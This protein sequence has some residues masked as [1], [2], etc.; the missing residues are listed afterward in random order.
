MVRTAFHAV[1][2][3]L[4]LLCSSLLCAQSAPQRHSEMSAYEQY[5][6]YWT[7]EP[8]WR[9]ELQLRNNLDPGELTVTP[10]LRTADGTETALPPVTIKSGD[11]ASL[12][13]A[14]ALL[15]AAPQLV[16]SYGS[17]VLGYR[18]SVS[19]ALYAAVMVG[20][21]GHPIAFH[22]DARFHSAVPT[23]LSREG[24]WWL[25]RD[26]VSDYLIL[27]NAGE[28]K[29]D[30][31]LALYDSNGRAWRHSL[32]VGARQT[33]RLSVRSL[34][35]RAG[36]S[37]LY[38]GIQVEAE[39]GA[40]PL[41][42]THLIFD[43]LGGFG[44]MMKMFGHDPATTLA[45]RSF[46]GAKEWTTRAPM[47]ALSSPDPALGL[48]AG[49][50][51]QPKVFVR[52]TSTKTYTAHIRFNWRSATA[53]GKTAPID[54][55]LKPN[56]AQAVDVAALQAQKLIPADAHWAAVV[57]SAPIQPDELLAVAASYDQSGRYGAQT[58]FS[59][60]L[61]FHWEGGMWQVDSTHNSLITATN[62]GSQAVQAELTILYNHGSSQY[63][64]EQTLAPDEQMLVDLGKLIRNQVPDK[65]GHTLPPD[66][67][68][69]AY[70]LR[71]LTDT[72][73]GNLYEGKVI[74]DKTY[75]H[76]AYGCGIC[77]G[78][79]D[80][81]MGYDPL[82]VAV[83]SSSAQ[84]VYVEESCGGGTVL[85]TEDF[86]TWSTGNTAI[87][88][89]NKNTISGVA[90]GT[91]TDTAKSISLALGSKGVI[92]GNPCPTAFFQASGTTNVGPYQV[93][94]IDTASQ[95]PAQCK[96]QGQAGWVRNVTNQVQ[97]VNGAA[98][99]VSGLSVSDNIAVG[100][101]NT[102]GVSSKQEGQTPTTG[103]GSFPDTYFVCST[104]CPGSGKTGAT[105]N[106]IV[107]GIP[108]LHVDGLVY[109]CG[110][111]SI[112]GH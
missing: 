52:N 42:T 69:G 70:R 28:Q 73:V 18:A 44:A 76:A 83:A 66:L 92:D 106:W 103:D 10:A 34:L 82:G 108:L 98:Y 110:S 25:P 29:V 51:L 50:I 43:E 16:G 14:D 67:T 3:S 62:G 30:A 109:E 24:I 63:K 35:Q 8:G 32:S 75:G 21:D 27:S 22:V 105:Q 101:P 47:L 36:L 81:L 57:L 54:L 86:P 56:A 39:G 38:G 4:L 107:A 37:G 71:D 15:K 102:L 94:P 78:Y 74:V 9:T 64:V 31:S 26:S 91:T 20:M 68:S 46:G 80:A 11:V 85:L 97:Y 95:G 60:Q 93:E 1:A 7:T 33:Q 12:D 13:L 87:A 111:I 100:A 49:T 40:G 2:A 5:V 17:L 61:A 72:A 96:V 41:D 59:D 77:C 89:A 99:A 104:A 48:P 65:D 23:K 79:V 6:A 84:Q 45:S 112:D 58:P 90:A 19:G 55:L 88:T 53:A